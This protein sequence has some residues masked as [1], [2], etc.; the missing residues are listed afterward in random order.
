MPRRGGIRIWRYRS[1]VWQYRTTSSSRENQDL[2]AT[3]V[4]TTA[5]PREDDWLVQALPTGSNGKVQSIGADHIIATF[6]DARMPKDGNVWHWDGDELRRIYHRST[7]VDRESRVEEVSAA[8]AGYDADD[9]LVIFFRG[10]NQHCFVLHCKTNA[11]EEAELEE[12]MGTL[13]LTAAGGENEDA[14]LDSDDQALIVVAQRLARREREIRRAIQAADDGDEDTALRIVGQAVHE[15]LMGAEP[16]PV[17]GHNVLTSLPSVIDNVEK[18]DSLVKGHETLKQVSD[19]KRSGGTG[20]F[21]TG[22]G[23]V[24]GTWQAVGS[25]VAFFTSVVEGAKMNQLSHGDR[26]AKHGHN[27]RGRQALT[28]GTHGMKSASTTAAAVEAIGKVASF[29]TSVPSP[30][31]PVIGT[32]T[33]LIATTRSS[34]QADKSRRRVAKLKRALE[35]HSGSIDYDVQR[36]LAYAM[37]KSKRKFGTRTAEATTAAFGTAGSTILIVGAV[38]AGAN[39]WNPVGWGIGIAVFIAG[40]GLLTY[41]IVRKGTSNRRAERRGF[42]RTEFPAKLLDEF[43]RQFGRSP[44]SSNTLVLYSVLQAYGVH[45]I[46]ILASPTTEV[47]RA[48]DRIARHLKS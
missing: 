15:V 17:Q 23:L 14:L 40:A 43:H 24:D 42:S 8:L 5:P 44:K 3:A 1:G 35:Q 26:Q 48:R 29:S 32:L 10:V 27:A 11:W 39:A 30:L 13:E 12:T 33:G 4:A 25:I 38:L 37:R 41:K 19:S 31:T 7:K 21:G 47:S 22:V 20:D 6:P 16:A 36:L 18:L 28:V 46:D 45:P 34:I 2:A 9:E